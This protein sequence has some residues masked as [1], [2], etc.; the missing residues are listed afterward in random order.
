M[1]YKIEQRADKFVVVREDGGRVVG[2]HSSRAKATAQ[3][4]ALYV[5]V[6]DAIE[7]AMSR[8]EAGRYAAEQ[9]WKNHAK[10][11]TPVSPNKLSDNLKTQINLVGQAMENVRAMGVVTQSYVHE[12][13]NK[14]EVKKLKDELL[15]I[16]KKIER[17]EK[18][19]WSNATL[20]GNEAVRLA[21]L[22]IDEMA[23]TP[24]EYN[25]ERGK[26][27]LLISRDSDGNLVGLAMTFTTHIE[28][29]Q[30]SYMENEQSSQT[31]QLKGAA[32]S[33]EFLVS[34]QT[35]KGMGRALF[36]EVI[37]KSLGKNILFTQLEA[38]DYSKDYWEQVG[39]RADPNSLVHNKLMLV[40][41]L[42]NL[43]SLLP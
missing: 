16:D 25:L 28:F 12:D 35:V 31:R 6:K 24:S 29:T 37:K 14:V 9:R 36:G 19:G 5:N 32:L 13:L 21:H 30:Q 11:E 41:P 26:D 20:R 22:A 33:L 17:A 10:Q 40:T 27:E 18:F 1:P 3:L 38:T 43:G 2:T 15:A 4:R 34:F 23:K 7:K 42:D 8:S 39:F